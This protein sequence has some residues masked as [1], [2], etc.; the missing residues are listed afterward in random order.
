M[1]VI[2]SD[3]ALRS[4]AAIHKRISEDSEKQ[5]HSVIDGILKWGD[6]L[7]TFPS[8]GRVV[9]HYNQPNIRELIEGRYRIVYRIPKQQVEII[10]IFHTEQRPAWER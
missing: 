3:Q 7:E 9:T 2:W 4:L 5:A 8:S 10:E 1:K 6:Q